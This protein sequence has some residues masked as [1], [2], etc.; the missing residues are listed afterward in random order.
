MVIGY[1]III[2]VY[3]YLIMEYCFGDVIIGDEVMIGVNSIIFLGVIIGNKVVV[4]VGMVVYKD[5]VFGFFV[6]GNFMCV[7]YIKEEMEKCREVEFKVII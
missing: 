2:F 1:N 5:V 3:E 4:V 7:I 6:G